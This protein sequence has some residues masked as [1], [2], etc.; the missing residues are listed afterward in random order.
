MWCLRHTIATC[1]LVCSSSLPAAV[2]QGDPDPYDEKNALALSQSAIGREIRNHR[3]LDRSNTPVAFDDLTGK[4]LV[5]SMI[6]T[7]CYHICPMLTQHLAQVVDIARE[8][9]GENRFDVLTIGFDTAVDTPGRMAQFAKEQSID[10]PSWHFLSTDQETVDALADDLGFIYFA[11]AK[12]FDHLTQTTVVDASGKV[13]RQ[14][15]GQRFDTPSLVEPLKELV[16]NSPRDLGFV[17]EWIE[18][19][20]LFCTIFDPKTGRYKF[21]Y[22]IFVTI[23]AG[24]LCLGAIAWFIIYSWR[25]AR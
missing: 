18:N 19:V 13:Y 24:V 15:Y 14:V 6:Y 17:D 25:D 3:F 10:D 2:A 1:F 20:R 8:T 7:S 11:S 23:F 5:V 21:D 9:L 16:Y 22:S 12:G 4:P